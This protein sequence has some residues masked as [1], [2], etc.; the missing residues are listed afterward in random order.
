MA[1]KSTKST[2]RKRPSPKKT[3]AANR[4]ASRGGATIGRDVHCA[5]FIGRDQR[6]TYGY[7][8]KDVER[9]IEKVLAFLSGGATFVPQGDLLRAE[10]NGETLT[11]RPGAAKQLAGRRNERSYLLSLTVRQDYLI[12]AT[13]FIPLA[14]RMDVKRAVEALNMP[15][16]YSEFRIPREGEAGQLTALPL[17]D[18]AEAFDKHSAFIILGEPGAGKTTTLQKYAFDRARTLLDGGQGRVPLLVRLSEQGARDPFDFLQTEWYRRTGS[19]FADALADGRVL[20]LADGV[21]ELGRS[22]HDERVVKLKAWRLFTD[23][24]AGADQIVF[25]SREKDYDRQLDLPR[26]RVDP[27]DDDRIADYLKRNNAEGLRPL[28]DDAR[29]HLREMARNP[30]NLSLLTKA[31]QDNQRDMGNRGQLL[32]WFVGELFAREEKLAH[33]WWLRRDSQLRALSQLAYAM[34]LQGESKTFPLKVAKAALPPTVEEEGEDVPL[35]PADLFRCG[36]A[37]TILDPGTEPDIRFYHQLL[38]EYFA[39]L[40]LLR[41]FDDGEDL[42][43]LWKAKRL[44]DE[45]PP[46]TVGEWDPLPEPPPTDWEVTTI[47][48]CGLAPDPARLIEAVRPHN[49]NLAGRCIDEAGVEKPETVTKLVRADLLAD[50]YNPNVHLRARLQAG[51]TLGRIG[52]PRFEP[53]VI[54]GVKVIAPTMVNVPA[55]TYTIGSADDD[56]DAYDD[57]KPQHSV[58]LPAFAI[59]QWPVTNAEY[60]CFM[61]AGGYKDEQWWTTELAERWLR[62][63]EVMGGQMKSSMDFWRE[64]H[65]DP[66]RLEREKAS[67]L[68]SPEQQQVLDQIAAM[69]EEQM[70]SAL[71]SGL[72]SK[73]RER[74]QFWDD[75]D[76]NNPSQPVVGITWFEANA[77]CEWLSAIIGREYRLPTEVEWEA[78]ARGLNGRR[79]PW[80]D[81]WDG[82]KANTIE[83]RVLKPSPVGVYTAAGSAG[84][85]GAEDQAGNV[86]NWTSALYQA[87]PY[88]KEDDREE[89]S[90]EGKRA[91]RGGSWYIYDGGA[92]CACRRRLVPVTFSG[93]IGFRLL[94]PGSI[95]GF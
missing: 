93:D 72:S 47:L 2:S 22:D 44:I 25:T 26:V 8:A 1:K 89:V 21:N 56:P 20:V 94:S 58:D 36:R 23:D 9:L 12:W 38:Q 45:M 40:E 43:R 11:F 76:R 28:L 31:Y 39:A 67:G 88:K 5:D 63:E 15:I 3:R 35:K 46:A 69:S 68:Y 91:V 6:I 34:Q 27:L 41:R 7:T 53:Q 55:G 59:G 64:L 42:S 13:R 33:R 77:Y 83:G 49:P 14:G 74:P 30:F 92:R 52:D 65:D 70:R 75:V 4:A 95:S 81:E 86:W 73:S 87:Y 71:A 61:E 62:G 19:D 32:K 82:G 17:A 48:A 78:A 79:Y 85:F 57:E 54:N 24:Y 50:L 29:A 80:G 18:I 16:A 60:A 84:P 66:K 90:A 10:L 37:A 51:F